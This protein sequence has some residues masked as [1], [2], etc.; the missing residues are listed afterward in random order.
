MSYTEAHTAASEK[1]LDFLAE[2]IGESEILNHASLY[3]D[4]FYGFTPQQY[5]VIAALLRKVDE[6]WM[7]LTMSKRE[8]MGL[9]PGM[10][11]RDLDSGLFYE[12]LNTF[13]KL[14]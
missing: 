2:R 7:A 14:E 5:T 9:T 3:F 4:D 11:W 10:S 1:I 6:V 13:L 12:T 8:Y